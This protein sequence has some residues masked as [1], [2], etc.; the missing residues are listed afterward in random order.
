MQEKCALLVRKF[1]LKVCPWLD[2]PIGIPLGFISC[3][4]RP[5]GASF[6]NQKPK[7]AVE[8]NS[9]V[10][11]GTVRDRETREHREEEQH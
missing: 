7:V 6:L 9:G 1:Q 10:V 4:S 3:Y 5:I 11:V 2:V 8:G